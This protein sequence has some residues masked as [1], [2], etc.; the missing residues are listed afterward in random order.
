VNAEKDFA[1]CQTQGA[2]SLQE[3][4]CRFSEIGGTDGTLVVMAD[5]MGGHSAGERA[6]A[7]AVKTFVDI[8]RRTPGALATRMSAGLTVANEAIRE[9]LKQDAT[10]EGMGTT[11]VAACLTPAGLEWI[12]VGDSPLYLLR[13]STLK[14]L[15]EDHSLRP[16][17]KEMAERGELSSASAGHSVSGN[18]LRAALLGGEIE[19]IDQSP[20]PLSLDENDLVIAATDGIHTLNEREIVG[21]CA[22]PGGLDASTLAAGLIRAV[23]AANNPKQDNTTIAI[24]KPRSSDEGGSQ[25]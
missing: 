2:R 23:T 15:N 13:G 3:D 24:L 11:L 19:M 5:G 7:L 4:A 14:R 1:V 21:T 9:E 17:L 8:F 6:S 12:S 25:L 22:D 16:I 18:I 10:L 20:G